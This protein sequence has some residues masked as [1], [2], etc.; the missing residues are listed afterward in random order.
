MLGSRSATLTLEK[1]CADHGMA[2]EPK[3][4]AQRVRGVEKPAS[5]EQ[6]QR[7]QVGP[8]EAV[9]YRRVRLSCGAHVLSEADNRYVP[10][11][12]TPEI[13]RLLDTTDTPFGRA[14]QPLKPAR[15]TFSV[16]LRVPF[17]EVDETYAGAVLAFPNAGFA[18]P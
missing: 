15:Q 10:A 16:E 2:T 7:L 8:D 12:L 6:R 11:R 5:P 9:R 18:P 1:W 17:S 4:V 14:V 13:N 3:I